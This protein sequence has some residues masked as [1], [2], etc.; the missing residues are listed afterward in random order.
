L[1]GYSE[2][3]GSSYA[4]RVM[5]F[6]RRTGLS[7]DNVDPEHVREHLL[8][9]HDLGLKASTRRVE[10]AALRFL[11]TY[12]VFRPDVMVSIVAP[13]SKAP[14][15]KILSHSEVMGVLD[16]L[17]SVRCRMAATTIYATG[18]RISEVRAL[19]ASDID[20]KRML[21]H[22]RNGKG[23]KDRFVPL[24][25]KL[26]HLLRAYWTV[27]RPDEDVLFP[28]KRSF[29]KPFAPTPLRRALRHAGDA[30]G[31]V[32]PVGPHILR[33]T[34][35]THMLELGVG[36]RELQVLLGHRSIKTTQHYTQVSTAHIARMKSPFDITDDEAMRLG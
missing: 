4:Q 26:L 8:Y 21:I 31:L 9:L 15:P 35:A 13:K 19:R 7:P 17:T 12:I 11:F 5:R 34:Y 28:S 23:G 36:I 1:R 32:K 2:G 10:V 30:A 24:T 22:V 3:T 29:D 20:S 14:L 16:A 25:P 6:V 27:V 33:H 18:M